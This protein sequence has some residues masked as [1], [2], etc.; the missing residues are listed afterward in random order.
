MRKVH[1]STSKHLEQLCTHEHFLYVQL[2]SDMTKK[3]DKSDGNP[4]GKVITEM[5]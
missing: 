2:M 4:V 5:L 1:K 3:V